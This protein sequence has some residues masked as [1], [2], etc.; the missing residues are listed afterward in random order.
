M[1][2]IYG[3]SRSFTHLEKL[4]VQHVNQ[5]G[6]VAFTTEQSVDV[7]LDVGL[8]GESEQIEKVCIDFHVF[9]VVKALR[10]K[11]DI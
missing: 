1:R 5:I 9:D 4:F 10:K 11:K 8:V 6:L 7:S 3:Q 2:A